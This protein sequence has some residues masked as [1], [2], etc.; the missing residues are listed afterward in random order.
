ML[1]KIQLMN[2]ENMKPLCRN[3]KYFQIS[4]DASMPNG[5]RLYAIKSK[6]M[7]SVIVKQSSGVE[8]LGFEVKPAKK[9]QQNPYGE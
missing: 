8:C 6:Q 7:P 1:C 2:E 4:W 5:C 3:C 9:N